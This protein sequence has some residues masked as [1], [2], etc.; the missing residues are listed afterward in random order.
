LG[1]FGGSAANRV[2]GDTIRDMRRTWTVK[3]AVALAALLSTRSLGADTL[4]YVQ[5][6][7]S[8]LHFEK[9]KWRRTGQ[10][11]CS[12]YVAEADGAVVEVLR[13]GMGNLVPFKAKKDLAV[14]VCGSV[15]SFDEGFETGKPVEK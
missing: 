6:K 14:T 9:G 10:L 12:A 15:V 2:P 7:F 4:G 11:P 1:W 13:I 5:Q 3:L 8:D